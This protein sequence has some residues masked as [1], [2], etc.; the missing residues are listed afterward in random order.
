MAP[1]WAIHLWYARC[2]RSNPIFVDRLPISWPIFWPGVPY[3]Q[4]AMGLS[5]AYR[6]PEG[7]R[8]S[9]QSGRPFKLGLFI[10]GS[11]YYSVR[12]CVRL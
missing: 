3:W 10:G 2:L 8:Q 1:P 4:R 11:K 6:S 7:C 9:C 12:C 5:S